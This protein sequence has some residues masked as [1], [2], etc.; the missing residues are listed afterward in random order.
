MEPRSWQEMREW[1]AGLLERRT[2]STVEEWNR[3]ITGEEF[4]DRAALREWLEARGV[5][6]YAQMLLVN[7]R[8]GYL[9]FFLATADELIDGQYADRPHLRP[10]FDEVVAAYTAAAARAGGVAGRRGPLAPGMDA[11]LVAWEVDPAAL[12]GDGYAFRAGRAALTVVG[13]EVVMRR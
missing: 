6:G 10:V 2:G 1:C 9:D 7:E 11:D 5:T 4:A 12:D 3:R 13:G 8:F